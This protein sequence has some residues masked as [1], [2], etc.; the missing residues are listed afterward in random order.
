MKKAIFLRCLAILSIGLLLFGAIAIPALSRL[1]AQQTEQQ[2]HSSLLLLGELFQPQEDLSLQASSFSEILEQKR[3]TILSSSGDILADSYVP[4]EKWKNQSQ[5]VEIQAALR[6][7]T[8]I[9]RHFSLSQN[10]NMV[11]AALQTDS[12]YLLR[13]AQP[14]TLF[15]QLILTQ[16]PAFLIAFTAALFCSLFL[17]ARF[18][19][20][21]VQ[22][23]EELAD[24]LSEG[25]DL[26]IVEKSRYPE[27]AGIIYRIN[28]LARSMKL[29]NRELSRER[30]KIEFIL[31]NLEE[32]LVLLDDKQ[33]LLTVSTSA[34]RFV[35]CDSE[36]IGKHISWLVKDKRI[37]DAVEDASISGSSRIFDYPFSENLILS[38]HITQVKN[39]FI[40]RHE[41]AY[42]AIIMIS[43]VT[44]ER[45]AQQIRQEFFSNAS[46]ELKTPITSIRGFAELLSSDLV[47]PSQQQVSYLE[48]IITETD[49]MTDLLN[50][51]LMISNLESGK[52]QQKFE[53]V[54]LTQIC[55]DVLETLSPEI[56]KK[57]LS[58]SCSTEPVPFIS[59]KKQMYELLTNIISNAVKYNRQNGRIAIVLKDLGNKV[60]I[61]VK[62]T[63]IGIPLEAQP[64]IFER[65]YRVDKGRSRTLG[66]TGL[67]L[68]IVKHIVN[69]YEG[70]ITL[71][72]KEG[73]GTSILIYLPKHSNMAALLE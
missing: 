60:S 30:E 46:H 25:K 17:S 67:G 7:E 58:L 12:G 44:G 13:I 56:E 45:K 55:T 62:D 59:E 36:V 6:G 48:R 11:Y 31:D 34:K 52:R 16:A 65:F 42:G 26:S 39:D 40:R 29:T 33:N 71:H 19:R 68:S 47:I 21:I 22:P 64:R 66:G 37:S 3:V 20:R 73:E 28:G 51:I 27:L 69:Q 18:T 23:L 57:N 35:H 2:L 61:E 53:T 32:G 38:L 8:G 4:E 50:D 54:D 41:Y 5:Y 14:S 24:A 43:D 49:R 72:S 1:F 10:R 63:G 9:A 15:F 70:E